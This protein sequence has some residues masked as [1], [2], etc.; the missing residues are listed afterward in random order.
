M[1]DIESFCKSLKATWIK[2]YLDEENQ[3]NLNTKDTKDILKPKAGFISEVLAVW[4][5]A[6]LEDR[7]IL[8]NHFLNQSLW[9]NSL[10]RI[11][12]CPVFYPEWHRKGTT[13]VKHLKDNSNNFL[14]LFELQARYRLKVCP[15]KCCGLLSTL[16]S[17]WRTH[18]DNFA[19]NEP[20]NESFLAGLRKAQKASPL[21]YSKLITGKSIPPTQ[22]Q[23]K[24]VVDCDIKDD[25]YI[26]WPETYEL[27]SKCSTGT[28]LV[29]LQF[30][31]LHRRISTD[32][33]LNKI[34]VQDDPNSWLF[35]RR[36]TRNT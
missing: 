35:L 25:Q 20:D 5:E 8:E 14:S 10:I 4:A 7:I 15:F 32:D 22:T 1:I 21:V 16:K 29:E 3:S 31:L 9:Y 2:K 19:I 27:A 18:K 23:Q 24:W 11:D 12:N 26:K 13:K 33:F 17:L 34:G 28:R 30:K 6:F 36:R